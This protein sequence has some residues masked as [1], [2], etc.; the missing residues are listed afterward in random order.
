MALG[1]ALG[2]SGRYTQSLL[3]ASAAARLPALLGMAAGQRTRGRI[4]A[5]VF[6]R[7]FFLALA[8]VGLVM[9]VRGV[10]SLAAH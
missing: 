7:W 4:D 2:F 5:A 10:V 1:L 3:L 9:V 8:A 6:R